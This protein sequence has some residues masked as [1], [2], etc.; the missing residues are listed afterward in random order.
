MFTV[1]TEKITDMRVC[2]NVFYSIF[3]IR[4]KEIFYEY[5]FDCETTIFVFHSEGEFQDCLLKSST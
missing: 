4:R 3:I 1:I 2:W 5:S